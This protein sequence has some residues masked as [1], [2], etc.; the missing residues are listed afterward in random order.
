MSEYNELTKRLLAEGWTAGNHPDYVKIPSGGWDKSNPL[1]NLY[2]GFEY[3]RE[4][5]NKLVFTTG[6]G[7][8]VKGSEFNAGTMWFNGIDW[9]PENNNPVITCPMRPDSCEKR[10]SQCLGAPQG[11]AKVFQCDLR[12]VDIPWTYE[13]SLEK[14]KDDENHKIYEQKQEYIKRKHGRVCEWHMKYNY[15]EGQW[16]QKY[17]PKICTRFC[18]R[19]GHECLISGREVSKKRGNVFYDIKVTRILNDGNLFDGM[20][21]VQITRGKRY[22]E[23]PASLTICNEIVKRCRKDIEWK[24][25][26]A[27]RSE[28]FL[29]NVKVEA[30][31]IRAEYRESRDLLQDLQDLKDGIKIVYD[32]D[33]QKMTKEAKKERRQAAKDKKIQ[34]LENK[35][36]KIGFA[37]LDDFEKMRA[38]KL[39]D[40]DR[41]DQLDAE[42]KKPKEKEPEQMS[43]FDFMEAD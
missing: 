22:L 38:E 43:I 12:M 10:F 18:R 41:I 32:S 31:N 40:S 3:T 8:L 34:K 9:M 42:H 16:H 25:G 30:F 15:A 17:D 33:Q 6:C 20:E 27:Y 23:H 7:L 28:M 2:G 14:V 35:I 24:A 13:K 37:G 39:I 29:N 21:D 26:Q 36:L 4:Y 1:V 19:V 11:M 5:R